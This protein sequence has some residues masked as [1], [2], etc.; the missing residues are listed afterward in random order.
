MIRISLYTFMNDLIET[1][2]DNAAIIKIIDS[3]K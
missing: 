3:G 1:P 2:A